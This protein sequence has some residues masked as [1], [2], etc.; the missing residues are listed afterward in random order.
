MTS[1]S[2]NYSDSIQNYRFDV[3]ISFRGVDIRNSFVD[4]LYAHFIRKGLFV[5]KDDKRLEKGESISEQLLQAIKDS[6]ISIIVF[7]ENYASSSWCLEEMA[8]IFDCKQQLKQTVFPVFYDVDPSHLRYQ[9]GVYQNDFDLH[10][11]KKFKHDPDKIRRWETAMT[12]LANS[13][14]WDVRN[15]YVV[16]RLFY[17]LS[18][19]E[20]IA[21]HMF[22]CILNLI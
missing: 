17:S 4:H 13:A 14:G 20:F 18:F 21:Y 9:C 11:R 12:D 2:S 5:F 1:S 6:R 3:F 19:A 8:A 22:E 15:R 10:R 16:L 7:S